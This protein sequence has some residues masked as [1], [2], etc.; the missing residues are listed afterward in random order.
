M[1]LEQ[2]LDEVIMYNERIERIHGHA[3]AI[4]MESHSWNTKNLSMDCVDL[5]NLMKKIYCTYSAK[6]DQDATS[7]QHAYQDGWYFWNDQTV[8]HKW[9]NVVDS[10][11]EIKRNHIRVVLS[12]GEHPNTGRLQ[13]DLMLDLSIDYPST[14]N[15]DKT[16]IV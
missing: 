12:K 3:L 5:Y 9:E 1:S 14:L 16:S 6:D 11:K 4:L 15:F 8:N 10:V 7:E 13:H 2:F